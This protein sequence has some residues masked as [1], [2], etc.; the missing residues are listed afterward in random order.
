MTIT[1]EELLALPDAETLIETV[2]VP[3]LGMVQV[4]ALSLETHHEMRED[5]VKGQEFDLVRWEA[6]LLVHGLAEPV[7]KYDQ[8]IALR[9]KAAGPVN[10]LLTEILKISGL[11]PTGAVSQEA[12]DQAEETF[13]DG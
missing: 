5:C 2:S 13:R 9:K 7:V 4:R 6:L 8:A 3:G 1:I 12:V 11:T 10:V